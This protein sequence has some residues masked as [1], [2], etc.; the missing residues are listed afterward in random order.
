MAKK[1]KKP[2]VVATEPAAAAASSS[3]A[4]T[5]EAVPTTGT[6]G[7]VVWVRAHRTELMLFGLAFV[8]LMMFSA[9]RFWRQSEAP[10]FV[11]Q[12]KAWLEGR[13]DL[14]VATLP[15]MEDWACVREVNGLKTRCE[16]QPRENDRWYSSFPPFPSVVMLPFVL[17]NGYQLNDSSFG[18]FIGALAIA[19]F[20]SL[21]RQL[22][23]DERLERSKTD[24]VVLALLLGFGTVF[25]YSSLRGEVWFSAEV[26]GVAFTSL[27]LRHS[28][29]ARRPVLAGLLWSMAVLTRTPLFFTGLFFVLEAAAP[30]KTNRIEQLKNV[31]SN[32]KAKRALFQFAA[33]AAPL[34]VLSAVVNYSR[35]GS[36]TE[37]GHKFLFNNRVNGDID[38]FGLFHPHY[39]ERNLDAAFEKLPSLVNGRLLYTPWGLSL[40]L[41]LPFLALAFVP[42]AQWKRA[43]AAAG[44]MLGVL[45][46][47]AALPGQAPIGERSLAVV[48]MLALAL[49]AFAALAATWWRDAQAPRLL[50]P[51]LLTLLA[52]A[53]P[54]LL[55]QNTGYAQFGF[56]FSIDYTPYVILLVALGG[57]SIR[58]PFFIGVAVL[59]VLVNFWGAVGFRGYTE[60]MRNW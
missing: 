35:F 45:I 18:V 12:S 7:A 44:A 21:L 54:G 10:H 58:R 26:M 51:V 6:S 20:Y 23:H 38:T 37:F 56:R 40:F 16:G 22:G 43:W 8:V 42:E 31:F 14:D 32:E 34:G 28:V 50:V 59:A 4:A 3:G 48:L 25:F 41:T 47:S 5:P 9:Q 19:L 27:Y 1:N 55:Y 11:Y 13:I 52:C 39:L 2:E 29:R 53:G 49:G 57:W 60:Q 46:V 33:A 17:V 30:E 15:N 24:D 36:F